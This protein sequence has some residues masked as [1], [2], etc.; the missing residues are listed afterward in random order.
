MGNPSLSSTEYSLRDLWR[1]I[2][3]RLGIEVSPV[4]PLWPPD[5]FALCSYSLR[6]AAAYVH[7]LSNW[8]P[9]P[10][11]STDCEAVARQWQRATADDV[12]TLPSAVLQCWS[13]IGEAFDRPLSELRDPASPIAQSIVELMAYSDQTCKP[14]AARPDGQDAAP[15]LFESKALI[16]LRKHSWRSAC[17]EIDPSRLRVLPKA[18]V[19][20]RGLTI[21]SLSLYVPY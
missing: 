11:W 15:V 20:Q 19:P 21:R 13:R 18:R 10:N 8:P 7:V 9:S 12:P 4:I 14:L 3:P 16:E 2:V 5:V 17:R 1:S 6:Q